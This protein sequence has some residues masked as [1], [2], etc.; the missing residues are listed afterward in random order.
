MSKVGESAGET[1]DHF[2]HYGYAPSKPINSKRS[3]Y[4]CSRSRSETKR[5]SS[6]LDNGAKNIKP[7]SNTSIN[8]FINGFS[9]NSFPTL[10]TID[11][12][13]LM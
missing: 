10:P 1:L 6:R 12:G 11:S 2:T 9:N 4:S 8:H 5:E 13:M 3:V 7:T